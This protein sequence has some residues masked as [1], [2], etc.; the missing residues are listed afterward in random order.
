ME[1]ETKQELL[2]EVNIKK[3][4]IKRYK[5]I[6]KSFNSKKYISSDL[7]LESLRSEDSSQFINFDFVDLTNDQQ[8]LINDKEFFKSIAGNT[9]EMVTM[10]T[11]RSGQTT[12]QYDTKSHEDSTKENKDVKEQ[13]NNKVPY[14][15]PEPVLS[16][17]QLKK[18]EEMEET[19]FSIGQI[20]QWN[21][22][23]EEIPEVPEEAS[24]ANI[25]PRRM[26]EENEEILKLAEEKRNESPLFGKNNVPEV[27]E[28][29]N[30]MFA[31]PNPNIITKFNIDR[32][33]ELP[34][35]AEMDLSI[36]SSLDDSEA[37]DSI[38]GPNDLSA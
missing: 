35:D 25:T 31:D 30:S 36:L 21:K 33:I 24:S 3:L 27:V 29:D 12:S 7:D 34:K 6:N 19:D 16:E 8:Q 4:N 13:I 14:A 1:K 15:K 11:K 9:A 17:Q 28:I 18:E 26:E 37:E 32:E 10:A 2:S 5:S 38:F 22:N 20:N 23:C